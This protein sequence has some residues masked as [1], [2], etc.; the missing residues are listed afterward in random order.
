GCTPT[1]GASLLRCP[2]EGSCFAPWD[3]PA[4]RK[5]Y[6]HARSFAPSLPPEGSCFAPWDGPAARNPRTLSRDQRM[7]SRCFAFTAASDCGYFCISSSSVRRAAALSFKSDCADATF[8]SAS[9]TL[10]LVG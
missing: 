7:P 8:S 1:L 6:P 9:G 4:A 5:L 3:G 10:G 2:P